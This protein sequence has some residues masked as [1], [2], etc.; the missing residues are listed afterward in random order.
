MCRHE[1][2]FGAKCKSALDDFHMQTL[3]DIRMV[4]DLHDSCMT[5]VKVL[6]GT[7]HPGEG[8]VITCLQQKRGMIA[9]AKCRSA[10]L[11]ITGLAADDWRMD[12][13]LFTVSP[14]GCQP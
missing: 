7:I 11:R 6:C 9:S 14:C 2:D 12:F 5:E 13:N 1:L 8:R 3:G 4:K 10:L